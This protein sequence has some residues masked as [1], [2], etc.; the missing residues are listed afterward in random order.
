MGGRPFN[1]IQIV[2]HSVLRNE[3]ALFPALVPRNI[4][5][6]LQ[7]IASLE[8][9]TALSWIV[10]VGE[11]AGGR[12]FFCGYGWKDFMEHHSVGHG[13]TL[14]FRYV[15]GSMFRIKST[16]VEC[17]VSHHGVPFFKKE[18]SES[19]VS[20]RQPVALPASLLKDNKFMLNNKYKSCLVE[21]PVGGRPKKGDVNSIFLDFDDE[22][23]IPVLR[24]SFDGKDFDFIRQVKTEVLS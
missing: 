14:L 21:L 9:P 15:G 24:I 13:C 22:E 7:K 17:G 2:F 20:G 11:A 8:T 16:I 5:R 10:D 4:R 1:L 12:L 6:R 18:L 23:K 19:A 3:R